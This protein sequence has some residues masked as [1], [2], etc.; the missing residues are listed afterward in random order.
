MLL[1][2]SSEAGRLCREEGCQELP[3]GQALCFFQTMDRLS[4]SDI[5]RFVHAAAV[6]SF[7]LSEVADAALRELVCQAIKVRRLVALRTSGGAGRTANRSAELRRLLRQIEQRTRGRMN[8]AGRQYQLV[9]DVD[10]DKVPG[11][12]SYEVVSHDD[13]GRVLDGLAKE[14]GMQGDLAPL[15]GQARAKL[16]PDWRPPFSQPD[17]IVLL[18]K[19]LVAQ[20]V[21]VEPGPALTPSQLQ[22]L[23]QPKPDSWIKIH[24]VHHHTGE[25]IEGASLSLKLPN[26]TQASSHATDDEGLVDLTALPSGTFSIEG[27]DDDQ[28]WELVAHEED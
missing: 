2:P 16:T 17:G 4:A 21:A 22:Q 24:L 3:V 27:I 6:S 9:V 10:L 23:S 19:V 20:A 11:R 15:L 1:V 28:V 14:P 18:R 25:A 13:A 8:Y 5:R 7:P 12:S 26:A